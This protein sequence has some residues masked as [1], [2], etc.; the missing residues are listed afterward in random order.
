MA[1]T[2][3]VPESE[4]FGLSARI[5]G[6]TFQSEVRG[7]PMLYMYGGR[8]NDSSKADVWVF[9]TSS[10]AWLQLDKAA[11]PGPRSSASVTR[12]GNIV[13][14][15]GGSNSGPNNKYLISV[16]LGD[17]VVD[18]WTGK[19]EGG[20]GEHGGRTL[21]ARSL[22]RSLILPLPVFSHGK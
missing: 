10:N 14:F 16:A 13:V 18:L 21:A 15:L 20:V 9:N 19:G 1:W 4:V 6:V 8:T 2:L 17:Q 7:V 11:P 3:V 12:M 22:A 5:M